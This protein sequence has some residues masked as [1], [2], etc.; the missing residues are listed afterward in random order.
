LIQIENQLEADNHKILII[1]DSFSDCVISCLA[2]A[3]KNVDSLDIRYFTGS[4]KAYIEQSAPDL[5]I[6]MYN[7]SE[8]S[9]EIDY[10][11]HTDAFDFR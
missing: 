9:G 6:V 11:T 1:R 2:L 8:I 7:P 5:V 10:S 3:E 4:V